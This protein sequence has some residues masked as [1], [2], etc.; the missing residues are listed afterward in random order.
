VFKACPGQRQ[1]PCIEHLYEIIEKERDVPKKA[2]KSKFFL[3]LI[4]PLKKKYSV[5]VAAKICSGTNSSRP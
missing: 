4:V 3:D 5:Y 1:V 2:L